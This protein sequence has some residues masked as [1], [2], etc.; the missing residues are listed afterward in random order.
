M[1]EL[2]INEAVDDA[3][4][5]KELEKMAKQ[6]AQEELSE[7]AK[8]DLETVRKNTRKRRVQRY[9]ELIAFSRMKKYR[10]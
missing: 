6:R 5:L 1:P 7:K 2:N 10:G 8:I 4:V 9:K 3:N